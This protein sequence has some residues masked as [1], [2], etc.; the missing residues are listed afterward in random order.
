[1]KGPLDRQRASDQAFVASRLPEHLT[2]ADR[3]RLREIRRWTR[4]QSL[5]ARCDAL[6]GEV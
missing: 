6:L 3:A 5:A 2:D 1:M 4:D